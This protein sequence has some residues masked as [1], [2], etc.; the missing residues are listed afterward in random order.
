VKVAPDLGALGVLTEPTSVV[1]KARE[2]VDRVIAEGCRPLDGV[3]VTGA[4]P[5]GLLAALLAVQRGLRVHMLDRA[6]GG[7]K[8]RLV[9]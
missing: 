9:T 5:I 1:A 4:G 7:P 2:Q 6:A 3:L 8:P